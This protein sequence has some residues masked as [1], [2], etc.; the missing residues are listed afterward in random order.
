[1]TRA[2]FTYN[3]SKHSATSKTQFQIVHMK[4]PNYVL[5]LHSLSKVVGFSMSPKNLAEQVQVMDQEVIRKLEE[6][7]SRYKHALDKYKR[8]KLFQKGDMVIIFLRKE[9]FPVGTYNKLKMKK[10][11][12]YKILNLTRGQVFLKWRKLM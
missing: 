12:M 9:R 11:G 7:A 5:D 6:L 8:V 4:P 2:E 3:N 1:M 10:Y